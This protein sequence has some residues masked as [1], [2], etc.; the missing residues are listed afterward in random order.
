[1]M[2]SARSKQ[3]Q[4][5]SLLAIALWCGASACANGPAPGTWSDD[6]ATLDPLQAGGTFESAYVTLTL[7][8]GDEDEDWAL[9]PCG[10][11]P[12]EA[13]RADSSAFDVEDVTCTFPGGVTFTT[14]RLQVLFI[15]SDPI[16]GTGTLDV[17]GQGEV[18][19][20]AGAAEDAVLQGALSPQ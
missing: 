20:G 14:P 11:I 12:A 17:G 9:A 5:L 16:A 18:Q 13:H 19:V 2:R 6:L 15:A 3:Q 7:E 10:D 4:V 1:M 8:V